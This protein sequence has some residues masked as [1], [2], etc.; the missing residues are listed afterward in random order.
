MRMVAAQRTRERVVH[1]LAATAMEHAM[2][3]EQSQYTVQSI[4]ISADFFGKIYSRPWL[5]IECLCDSKISHNV[6]SSRQ[7]VTGRDL[8]QPHDRF[9]VCIGLADVNRRRFHKHP[10]P[11]LSILLVEHLP[12]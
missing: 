6:Q 1:V 4:G 5:L 3:S 10:S 11:A 12:E 9:G 2:R 7:P 8:D